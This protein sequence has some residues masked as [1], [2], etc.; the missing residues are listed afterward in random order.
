MAEAWRRSGDDETTKVGWRTIVRKHYRMP[1]GVETEFDTVGNVGDEVA[2]VIALTSDNLVVIAEQFRAGPEKIMQDLP[3]GMVDPGET[4]LQA[5]QRE[6]QEET[7]YVSEQ[8]VELGSAVDDA[9]SNLQRH[10]FLAT[11]CVASAKQVLGFTEFISV[12]L[13]TIDQLLYNATHGAMTDGLAVLY[14]Y[15]ELMKRKGV[16]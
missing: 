9:Y 8:W 11:D 7:G 15:D 3:G 4:A 16:S 1:D 12:K 13:L 10:F 5:A 6:L 2:A 14:A